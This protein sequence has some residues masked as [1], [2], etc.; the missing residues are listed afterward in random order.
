MGKPPMIRKRKAL[1]AAAAGLGV[2]V[3]ALGLLAF[4]PVTPPVHAYRVDRGKWPGSLEDLVPEYLK[5]V[6]LDARSGKAFIYRVEGDLIVLYGLGEDGSLFL[7]E[8]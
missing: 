2:L 5:A 7:D 8:E 1:L 3:L 4:W 6:P